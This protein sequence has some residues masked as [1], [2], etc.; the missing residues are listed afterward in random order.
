MAREA[1]PDLPASVRDR[2]DEEDFPA[3]IERGDDLSLRAQAALEAAAQ[4][5]GDKIE[6]VV[7]NNQVE[8][9]IDEIVKSARTGK[10]GDGKIFVQDVQQVIRIRTG[11]TGGDAAARR[12]LLSAPAREL[13][14]W[15]S[16]SRAGRS[17]R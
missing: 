12:A 17:R 7:A 4:V 10:I 9:A 8:S 13:G 2:I 11:E 1:R 6:V 5:V 14:G 3:Y 16:G 15:A